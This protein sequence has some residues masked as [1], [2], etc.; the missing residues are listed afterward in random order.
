L[1]GLP[2]VKKPVLVA[3]LAV[4]AVFSVAAQ[5][6][7]NL[8]EGFYTVGDQ[9][10]IF[11]GSATVPLFFTSFEGVTEPAL[12]HLKV[13]GQGS[14]EWGT[15]INGNVNVG[16]SIGFGFMNTVN[17]RSLTI[18]PLMAT[19][20]YYFRASRFDFPLSLGL[21]GAVLNL[22]SP[23]T[24]EEDDQQSRMS[25]FAPLIQLSGGVLYNYNQEWSFGVKLAYQA[26]AEIY[27]GDLASDNQ[28]AN[29][30]TIGGMVLY[31]F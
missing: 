9:T 26:S 16:G 22:E 5:D 31:H 2:I 18:V 13:G 30:A 10:F 12:E 24:S 28:L 11:S 17:D 23:M 25:A 20:T 29:F 19:G 6:S 7:P 1:Q 21:G 15:Y 14:L 3:L 4:A 8:V 27:F